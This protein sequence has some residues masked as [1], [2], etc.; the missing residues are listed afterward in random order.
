[1]PISKAEPLARETS[2]TIAGSR[3]LEGVRIVVVADDLIQGDGMSTY[4]KKAGAIVLG[5]AG[6]IKEARKLVDGSSVGAVILDS[7]LGEK[8][9]MKFVRKLNKNRVPFLFVT[10]EPCDGVQPGVGHVECV[11][12]P[13]TEHALVNAAARAVGIRAEA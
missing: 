3:P 12:K 1:M 13:Y 6:S 9:A 4:L 8:P 5:P 7:Y 11:E 2:P 10:G